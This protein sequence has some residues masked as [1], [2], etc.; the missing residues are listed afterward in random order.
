MSPTLA[1]PTTTVQ[2]IIGAITMRMSLMNP[3]PSGFMLSP[4][5][6]KK[7]PSA[8]PS[9]MPARTWKCSARQKALPPPTPAAP[10]QQA[11]LLIGAAARGLR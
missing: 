11:M 4:A 3:S 6:G 9:T 10:I 8:M 5:W 2:K 1:I 7:K